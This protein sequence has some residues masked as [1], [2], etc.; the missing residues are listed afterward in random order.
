[1]TELQNFLFMLNRAKVAHKYERVS[2][3]ESWELYPPGTFWQVVLEAG[4][5]NVIGYSAFQAE[6]YFDE[7][8]RLLKVGIW[9]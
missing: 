4:S 6:F 3:P 5:E 7:H 2:D 9:E 8:G 1:M